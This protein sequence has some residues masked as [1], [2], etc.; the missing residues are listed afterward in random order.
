MTKK[1]IVYYFPAGMR[2]TCWVCPIATI[3]LA[4]NGYYLW[5]SFLMFIFVTIL[6]TRYV[7][8][9]DS[10]K[11]IFIDYL[12]FL[13]IK[14]TYEKRSYQTIQ[15]IT[16]ARSSETQNVRS[17]IHDRQFNWSAY[18]ATLHFDHDQSLDLITSISL[19]DVRKEANMYAEFLDTQVLT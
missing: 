16:I 12:F 19:E 17:R 11:R 6:T 13:G 1:I 2:Y 5:A 10:E 4:L 18:T 3:W 8:M 15:G 14:L 9:I 7:T